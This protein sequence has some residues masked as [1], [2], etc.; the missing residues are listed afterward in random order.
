MVFL[1]AVSPQGLLLYRLG[2]NITPFSGLF[3][4][5][6]QHLVGGTYFGPHTGGPE[7]DDG[8]VQL[9]LG[10]PLVLPAHL[11]A[12]VLVGFAFGSKVLACDEKLRIEHIGCAFTLSKAFLPQ[13]LLLLAALGHF[14][15]LFSL[16]F[17]P[18]DQAQGTFFGEHFG[19]AGESLV[20]N[21]LATMS[22]SPKSS[23]PIAERVGFVKMAGVASSVSLDIDK[24]NISESVLL[25]LSSL[26]TSQTGPLGLT[27][28]MVPD[29][30][31]VVLNFEQSG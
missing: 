28:V 7:Y 6:V 15:L 5:G 21:S 20:L 8:T 14:F 31:Q 17:F 25:N 22:L 18:Q 1:S 9:A 12:I 30:D 29:E 4:Y 27:A 16:T 19:G 26:V 3:T 2:H 11:K 23:L 13:S 10:L 24:S